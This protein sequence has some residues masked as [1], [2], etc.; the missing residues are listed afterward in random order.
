MNAIMKTDVAVSKVG[1]INT[2]NQ[3]IYKRFSLDRYLF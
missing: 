2:P 1:I 3:P